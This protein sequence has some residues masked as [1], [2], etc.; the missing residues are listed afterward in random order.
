MSSV[1]AAKVLN[2]FSDYFEV[3]QDSAGRRY[4]IRTHQM[5]R[6]FAMTFSGPV[7]LVA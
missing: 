4:Y 6:F 7:G 3:Q 2:R 1:D 5:R